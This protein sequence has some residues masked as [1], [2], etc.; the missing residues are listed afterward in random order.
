MDMQE[1]LHKIEGWHIGVDARMRLH[2]QYNDNGWL[3]ETKQTPP[4]EAEAAI[5]KIVGEVAQGDVKVLSGNERISV[6]RMLL[7]S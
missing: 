3:V 1:I 7:T 6:M 4:S 2:I 5:Q